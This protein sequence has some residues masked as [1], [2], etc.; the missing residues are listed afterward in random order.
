[1]ATELAAGAVHTRAIALPEPPPASVLLAG[2]ALFCSLHRA[3]TRT[4]PPAPSPTAN[5]S[6]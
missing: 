5:G 2:S 4:R 6:I 3:R 1:M